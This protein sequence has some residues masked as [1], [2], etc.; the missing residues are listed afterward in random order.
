MVLIDGQEGFTSQD[1]SLLGMVVQSGKALVL[2]VNKWD[3]LSNYHRQQIKTNIER[4][5]HFI[6]FTP[7][8]YISALHGSNIRDLFNSVEKVYQVAMTRI[9]TNKLTNSLLEATKKTSN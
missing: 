4:K 8:F 3:G 2:G 7:L 6:D 9:S 1:A 5:L